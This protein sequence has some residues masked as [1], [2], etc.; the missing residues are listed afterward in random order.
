MP[1]GAQIE[2]FTTT[3]SIVNVGPTSADLSPSVNGL[4]TITACYVVICTDYI[5][6]VES[7]L[8]VQ[9]F[10][11]LSQ[12]SDVNS[13]TITADETV[14][15]SAYAVDQ[16][17]NLVTN[18]IINFIVSNGSISSSN[19]FSPYTVGSQ[20]VTAEWVGLTTSL[21]EVLQVQVT[22]CLLY[23]SPSPRDH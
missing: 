11:S 7:G 13:I 5:V 1:A 4:Q 19:V 14:T 2:W 9:I 23:T 10:A 8:P 18:E 17:G 20:T 16:H 12:N 3:G 21:Q 6:D 15:V 22:P